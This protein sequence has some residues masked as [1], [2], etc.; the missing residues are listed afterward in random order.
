VKFRI[1]RLDPM[2][3]WPEKCVWCRGKPTIKFEDSGTGFIGSGFYRWTRGKV[4]LQYPTCRRHG[5]WLSVLQS[6]Y[7][8][9]IYGVILSWWIHYLLFLLLFGAILV[10][11]LLV[12]PVRIKKVTKHFYTLK[13][14]DRDYAKEFAL[15]NSL[16]PL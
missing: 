4:V 2:V 6:V 8:I 10:W 13:I 11:N 7:P 14:R 16:D 15:L 12:R 3:T 9:S 1:S 5:L